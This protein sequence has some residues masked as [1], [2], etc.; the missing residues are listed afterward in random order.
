MFFLNEKNF[1]L[2]SFGEKRQNPL[3]LLISANQKK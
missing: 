1:K 2:N 3:N